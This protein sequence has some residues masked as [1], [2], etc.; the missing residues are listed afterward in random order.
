MNID[1]KKPEDEM[2]PHSTRVLVWGKD[3]KATEP[4]WYFAYLGES[5]M[6]PEKGQ[7]FFIDGG[8]EIDVIYWAC[9]NVPK[10]NGDQE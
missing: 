1:L 2:P 5:L 3:V 6:Q 8:R 10:L 9:L 4:D 7:Y